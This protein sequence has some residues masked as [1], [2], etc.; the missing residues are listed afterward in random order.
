MADEKILQD[1]LMTDEQLEQVAG[2]NCIESADDSRFLNSLNG[3]TDRYGATRI[4]FSMGFTGIDAEISDAWAKVGVEAEID[5]GRLLNCGE[6]NI[7]KING[8]QVTQEEARKHAMNVVG[9]QMTESDW[10]W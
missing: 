7:Y 2:G 5:S 10:K 9:K 3:S 4:F 1:E 6:K 8:K